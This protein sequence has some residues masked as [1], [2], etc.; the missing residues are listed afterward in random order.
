M[1]LVAELKSEANSTQHS[2][3]VRPPELGPQ[4]PACCHSLRT[5]E[6]RPASPKHVPS[7]CSQHL[8]ADS[9]GIFTHLEFLGLFLLNKTVSQ[10][11]HSRRLSVQF[12]SGQSLS[13]VNFFATM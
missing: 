7:T 8:S 1:W 2:R 12:S 11:K 13:R 4:G 9:F 6:P 5:K 10:R 3:W